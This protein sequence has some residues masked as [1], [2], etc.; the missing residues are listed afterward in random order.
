MDLA[1]RVADY[2]KKYNVP[3]EFLLDILEDQKVLPMIRGKATEYNAAE[4]LRNELNSSNWNVEKLNLSA[5]TNRYDEDISITNRRS[6]YRLKVESKNANRG[7]F[8]LGVGQQRIKQPHFKVKLHKSRSNIKLANTTNDRYLLG[9]FDIVLCNLSNAIFAGNTLEDTLVLIDDRE[10]IEYLM[11]FFKVKTKEEL[12][13]KSY[14]TWY[15]CFPRTI[16]LDDGSIPRSPPVLLENDPNWFKASNLEN[17]LLNELK[18]IIK[19]K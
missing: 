4:L 17:V 14:D 6:G 8:R 19:Q 12:I 2:C 16:A 5:Q 10:A 15:C 1:Q 18:R 13:Q 3:D 11:D 7:S 9:D